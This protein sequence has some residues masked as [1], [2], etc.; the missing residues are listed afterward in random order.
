M[1]PL[2]AS[3]GARLYA[4][5]LVLLFDS[6]RRPSGRAV[7]SVPATEGAAVGGASNPARALLPQWHSSVMSGFW[8]DLTWPLE[9]KT[10]AGTACKGVSRAFCAPGRVM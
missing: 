8:A 4:A 6:C 2:V 3:T 9:D 5:V 7:R 1:W 10:V